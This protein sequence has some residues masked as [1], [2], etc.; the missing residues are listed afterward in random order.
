MAD[1]YNVREMDRKIKKIRKTAEELMELGGE[2]EAVNRNL[3]RLLASTK[4]LELNISDA[5]ELLVRKN[6]IQSPA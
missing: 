6:R 3:V 4:M 5:V 1:T 2:I